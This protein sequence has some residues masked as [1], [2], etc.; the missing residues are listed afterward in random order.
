VPSV[1]RAAE[2]PAAIP[3]APPRP[4]E[5]EQRTQVTTAA[6]VATAA[7]PTVSRSL[8]GRVKVKPD[9]VLAQR[10]RD[11]YVYV[12]QDLRR[13]I[14]VAAILFAVLIVIWVFFTTVDPFDIY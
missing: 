8:P 1:G 11:E 3:G 12:G 13:I 7:P 14:V 4:S 2:P 10:A 6:A 5:L 9:S